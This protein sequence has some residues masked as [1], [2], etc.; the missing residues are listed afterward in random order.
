MA[1]NI[2]IELKLPLLN[3][4]KVRAYLKSHGKHSY[5]SEQRDIYYNAPHRDFLA[6]PDEVN[7]WFRVRVEKDKAHLNYKDW[8]PHDTAI[9]THA[10]EYETNLDSFEQL[11]NILNALDFTKLVEV[12]K[13]REAYDI[14]ETEVSIDTVEDLGSFIELE[15]KGKG[16]DIEAARAH[17]HEVLRKIG[18]ETGELDTRG[19]PYLLLEKNNL[20]KR[21]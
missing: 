20:L 4:E 15:Y 18:A 21:D 10:I 16:S 5:T 7:E 6:N 17:L 8:Q 12:N 9:K 14:L 2:E 11:S 13:L 3:A 1:N 19:Y